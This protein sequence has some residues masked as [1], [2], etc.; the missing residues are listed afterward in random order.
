[1]TFAPAYE[2]ITLRSYNNII[3]W[4]TEQSNDNGS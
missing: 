3:H 2:L 1:M 4:R